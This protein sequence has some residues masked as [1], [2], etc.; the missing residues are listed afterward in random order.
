M[1]KLLIVESPTKAKTISKYLGKDYIVLSSFGHIRDLPKSQ[2]GVDLEHDFAPTYT[3]PTKSKKAVAELKR[4]AKIADTIYLATDEDR[5]GEAIAW[6]VAEALNL[7]ASKRKRITFHEI[8]KAAVEEAVK[9]PREIDLNLVNAQQARRILDRLVGYELSPFLW[10]KIRYG[11]SAGRV[12]SVATRLIVDRERERRAFD[13]EEFWT[14]DAEFKKDELN[15]PA[16]LTT[17]QGKKVDKLDIKTEEDAQKIVQDLAGAEARVETV[18]KKL[19]KKTPPTPYATSTLQIDA[20]TKLGFSAKQTMRLA[21]ELYETGRITYMRTDSMNMAEKFLDEA[22]VFI[23]AT[24]GERYAEGAKRY[25]TKKKGAQEAHE[26]I[27]PTDASVTPESLQGTLEPRTVKLYK[28]IWSRTIASQLPSA[29]LNR[30]SVDIT[31]KDY[32]FRANGSSVAFDGFMKVYQSAKEKLLPDLTEGTILETTSILPTQHFTEPPARFSDA[33][34]VKVLEEHGIGRPSTYAP[35]ISTII[36]RGYVERDDHKKLAPTDIALIV[37]DMLVE[38]FPQIVDYEFTATMENTLDEVA[39]GKVEWVPMMEAFYGPF[40]QNLMAK[41]KELVREDIMP[42]RLLG[43]DPESGLPVIVKTGRFGGFVQVGEYTKE[44]KEEG[45]PKPKSASLLKGMYMESVTLEQ[46][47]DCL[48]LPREVGKTEEGD[49]IMAAVGRFGPYLKAG[50]VTSSLKEP[51]EPLTIDEATARIILK[52]SA[53]L[54]KKMATPIAEYGEDP[55]TKGQILLKHGRFGPYL[56]DG[57]TNASLGKTR[58]PADITR[59]I[60]IEILVKKRAQGPSRFGKGKTATKK[61]PAKKKPKPKT[62]KPKE[63]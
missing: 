31:V 28:L 17:I 3:V 56:T 4:A 11:L 18:E 32:R 36:D 9:E 19:V 7:D 6:H 5:E 35:T 13:V 26:A 58:D 37:S 40:H 12:Q 43:N 23:K 30:T 53:E 44:D 25:K 63:S 49:V 34:L 14:I 29:E 57:E 15:F 20:N 22:Q 55:T 21:Q 48:S 59:E 52:E 51:H 8:T 42:D 61:P 39:E 50:E 46:A 60:A 33:S 62:K 47:L 2:L 54:K 1:S 45:K 27:R 41:T 10:Q 38:H 16:K 24:Y